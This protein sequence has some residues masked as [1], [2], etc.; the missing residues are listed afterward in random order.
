MTLKVDY[1]NTKIQQDHSSLLAFARHQNALLR[2]LIYQ[3]NKKILLHSF[4][5]KIKPENS[6]AGYHVDVGERFS[7]RLSVL[8]EDY[9]TSGQRFDIFERFLQPVLLLEVEVRLELDER[10]VLK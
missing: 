1:A 4:H 6:K 3:R 9:F 2:F 8:V 10:L 5:L 7:E